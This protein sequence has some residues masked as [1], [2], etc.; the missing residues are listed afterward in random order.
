MVNESLKK[1]S[2]RNDCSRKESE[3]KV[4]GKCDDFLAV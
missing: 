2:E 3:K 1:E 4:S